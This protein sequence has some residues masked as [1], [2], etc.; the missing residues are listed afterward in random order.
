MDWK[1][2][3]RT[4]S[5]AEEGVFIE[6]EGKGRGTPSEPYLGISYSKDRHHRTGG[7][8]GFHQTLT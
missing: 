7:E 8:G 2:K 5:T 1:E 4:E 6:L 3:V